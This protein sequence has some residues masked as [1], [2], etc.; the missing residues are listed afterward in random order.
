M[1]GPALA[2]DHEELRLVAE[3]DFVGAVVIRV[4]LVV[5]E[6]VDRAV[7]VAKEVSGF[8]VPGLERPA[9]ADD[10]RLGGLDGWREK[11]EDE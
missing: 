3:P 10:R 1:V 2:L 9:A 4:A 8:L 11:S 7:G 5:G 6:E